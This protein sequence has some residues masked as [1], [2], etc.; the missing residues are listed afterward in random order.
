[1]NLSIKERDILVDA[2]ILI[3]T[4]CVGY[5]T[6]ATFTRVYEAAAMSRP[7]VVAFTMHPFS[8]D[9]IAAAFRGFSLET[10]LVEQLRQRQRRFSSSAERQ[11]ILKTM[12]ELGM[13]ARLERTTGYIYASCYIS[14]PP[15]EA[16]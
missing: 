8:Y 5:A 2:D 4:G 15:G 13:N 10:R 12:A 7:W 1:R 16:L 11:A 3:S 14:T 6:E 9:E